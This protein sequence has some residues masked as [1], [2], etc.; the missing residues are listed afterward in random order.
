MEAEHF[1]LLVAPGVAGAEAMILPALPDVYDLVTTAL[2]YTPAGSMQIKVYADSPALVANTLLSLPLI[3]GWNEPGEALKLFFEPDDPSVI[4]VVAHE[5]TH[6]ALFDRAGTM[7]TRMP[8]WLDEG[9]ASFVAGRL[10]PPTGEPDEQLLRVAEWVAAGELAPWA[11]MAVFEE[12]PIELWGF[13]YPQGYAM[14]TFVTDRYGDAKRNA[15]LAAMATDMT[16]QEATP[17]VLGLTFDE[18]DA[19]FQAWMLER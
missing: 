7:R 5:F 15:W 19:A 9:T 12:T 18:L 4:G 10:A 2:D 8:W 17:A 6:F 3:R 1:R 14:V 13:V 11:D 16:I